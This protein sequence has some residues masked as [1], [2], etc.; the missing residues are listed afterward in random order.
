MRIS[1]FLPFSS[2]AAAQQ[3]RNSITVE[4]FTQPTFDSNVSMLRSLHNI[5]KMF[6]IVCLSPLLKHSVEFASS[7]NI[8]SCDISRDIYFFCLR[9]LLLGRANTEKEIERRKRRVK[10]NKSEPSTAEWDETPQVDIIAFIFK[11][12]VVEVDTREG[13]DLSC[14]TNQFRVNRNET[15][16]IN[17]VKIIE[18]SNW[19]RIK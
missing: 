10:E 18:S 11:S 16:Q 8:I 13:E 7:V 12:K 14:E 1:R 15:V 17:C 9:C 2:S 4:C 3:Q 6:D 5:R 19:V